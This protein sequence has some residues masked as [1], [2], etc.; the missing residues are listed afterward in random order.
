MPDGSALDAIREYK[1]VNGNVSAT[2]ITNMLESQRKALLEVSGDGQRTAERMARMEAELS[3]ALAE[4]KR[5]ASVQVV[6]LGGAAELDRLYLR[7][8]GSVRLW[9]FPAFVNNAT[10]PDYWAQ[11]DPGGSTTAIAFSPDN[12]TLAR[13]GPDGI[14]LY[15]LVQIGRAHV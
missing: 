5:D 12:R 10:Q 14:K 3:R 4:A 2:D 7:A 1:P 15:N 9:Q 13:L 11:Q 8:D 6:A